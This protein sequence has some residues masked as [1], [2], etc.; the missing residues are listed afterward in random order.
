MRSPYTTPPE[1]VARPGVRGRAVCK[2]DYSLFS[3][4]LSSVRA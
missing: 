1:G 3:S 2:Q 4:V